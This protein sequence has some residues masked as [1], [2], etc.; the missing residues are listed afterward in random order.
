M[1]G[2]PIPVGNSLFNCAVAIADGAVLGVVP[3]QFLPNYKEFYE[4]RWFSPAVGKEPAEI[5]LGGRRVPFGIDLLFE[6]HG[7]DGEGG[8]GAL[9]VGV[10]ICEDLWVPIPPSAFQAMAG[11]TVLRQPL[12][13]QRDDRQE[14]VSHRPGGRP[15]GPLHGR[16][17]R[18]PAAGRPNRPPTW[19]SAAIA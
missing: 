2:A 8:P 17:T 15:V 3:K 7:T 11:A 10:E 16:R 6:A 14:P 1:V 19:S 13:E 9:V 12:G 18:W 5:E 4:S